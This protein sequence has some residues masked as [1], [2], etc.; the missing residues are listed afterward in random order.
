VRLD[1]PDAAVR[2]LAAETLKEIAIVHTS[3][4]SYV[5]YVLQRAVAPDAARALPARC[6]VQ[7]RS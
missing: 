1:H 7:R 3:E 2:G 6:T 4:A 5:F